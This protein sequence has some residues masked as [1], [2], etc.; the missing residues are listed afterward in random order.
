MHAP[1]FSSQ[2]KGETFYVRNN[3]DCRRHFADTGCAAH[4]ASQPAVGLLPE[5][6]A[7]LGTIDFDRP[8]T[9]GPVLGG[10]NV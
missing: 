5:R 2:E 9:I 1:S 7:W 4:L 3:F 6:R 10:W 8:D